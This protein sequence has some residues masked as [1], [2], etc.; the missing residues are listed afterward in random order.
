MAELGDG[1]LLF[2]PVGSW[3][4]GR[5]CNRAALRPAA[6]RIAA[7]ADPSHAGTARRDR[8]LPR[9][10]RSVATQETKKAR[11]RRPGRN[12]ASAM[13]IANVSRVLRK[14]NERLVD[15]VTFI[16]KTLALI[17]Y[18]V[19][20]Y[21]TV[22]REGTAMKSGPLVRTTRSDSFDRIN[23][24]GGMGCPEAAHG[25]K[26]RSLRHRRNFP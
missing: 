8:F 22:T 4:S 15:F 2:A 10:C 25:A 20:S 23:N 14:K 9:L 3:S 16:F 1:D 11:A 7:G 18:E 19:A 21:D 13:E 17:A 24:C 26:R 6:S 5:A 12:F